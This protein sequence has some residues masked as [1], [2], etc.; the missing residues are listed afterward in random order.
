MINNYDFDEIKEKLDQVQVISKDELKELLKE[1]NIDSSDWFMIQKFCQANN[2]EVIDP[3]LYDFLCDFEMS[4]NE[5]IARF[6]E[7]LVKNGYYLDPKSFF[8]Y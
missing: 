1:Y 5:R 4:N 2:I 7:Y 8:F 3:E 6:R